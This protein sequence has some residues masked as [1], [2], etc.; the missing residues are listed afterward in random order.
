MLKMAFVFKVTFFLSSW[1]GGRGICLWKKKTTETLGYQ[2]CLKVRSIGLKLSRIMPGMQ[3]C[4]IMVS[5]TVQHTVLVS[6]Q[7]K[8]CSLKK[9]N[10]NEGLMQ[11]TKWPTCPG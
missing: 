10:K 11:D 2:Q 1:G 6:S 9:E 7:T 4:D 8:L 5:F 3:E